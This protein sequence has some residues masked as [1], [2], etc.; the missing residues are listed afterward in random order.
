MI[1]LKDLIV[2]KVDYNK[3]LTNDEQVLL[4]AFARSGRAKKV[5]DFESKD[6]DVPL[7]SEYTGHIKKI[8]KT[9]VWKSGPSKGLP[10]TERTGRAAALF[11]KGK[12]IIR[13][14]EGPFQ[15]PKDV[16]KSH[17]AKKYMPAE[18]YNGGLA[19]VASGPYE[20]KLRIALGFIASKTV[21]GH[22]VDET[23]LRTIKKVGL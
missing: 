10:Q 5:G 8:A 14:K 11:Y 9:P 12:E 13:I 19:L 17:N 2:E 23:P 7:D 20:R 16:V 15:Y 6:I 21:K 3:E 22:W 1:K 18:R 4:S